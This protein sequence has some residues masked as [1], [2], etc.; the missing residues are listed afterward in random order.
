M[1]NAVCTIPHELLDTVSGGGLFGLGL[2]RAVGRF[3]ARRIEAIE[4]RA[5]AAARAA[6]L[7]EEQASA[8]ASQIEEAAARQG[9]HWARLG[10]HRRGRRR[11][12]SFVYPDPHG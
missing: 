6:R 12:L 2:W 11:S 4:W 10:G 3:A 5:G 7:A 9:G 1:A 8:A